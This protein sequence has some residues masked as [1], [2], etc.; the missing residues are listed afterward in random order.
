M[1]PCAAPTLPIR[2][3]SIIPAASP[4]AVSNN[5]NTTPFATRFVR[6]RPPQAWEIKW[7]EGED[8][9]DE[10]G[11]E[12]VK[13]TEGEGKENELSENPSASSTTDPDP[14]LLQVRSLT[15]SRWLCEQLCCNF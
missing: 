1:H 11:G 2:T 12:E 6:R 3:S 8:E 13:K 9:H 5:I 10:G 7:N 14:N 4:G 15:R